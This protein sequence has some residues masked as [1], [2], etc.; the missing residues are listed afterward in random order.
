MT[1][2]LGVDF[3]LGFA[4]GGVFG[5]LILFLFTKIGDRLDDE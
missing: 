4:F 1:E 2:K 3:L 5:Q